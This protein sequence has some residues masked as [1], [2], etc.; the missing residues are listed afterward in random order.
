MPIPGNLTTVTV[1]GAY[2]YT[3]GSPGV[4]TVSFTPTG[5]V[6]LR[7]ATAP[8]TVVAKKVEVTLSGTGTFSIALPATDDTD[9]APTGTTYDVVETVGAVTRTYSISLPMADTTVDIAELAPVAPSGSVS[10]LVLKVNNKLPNS[11][12]EVTLVHTDVGAAGAT[13]T[14]NALAGKAS[15]AHTHTQA[16][17][18]GLVSGLAAKVNKYTPVALTYGATLT[19]DATI[20][21]HYRVTLTGNATLAEPTGG[22]DGQMILLEVKQDGTGG[23]TLTNGADVLLGDDVTSMALSTGAGKT[24]LVLLLNNS[25]AGKWMVIGIIHGYVL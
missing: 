12:G 5:G 19:I 7:D 17:I 4:G 6:W 22:E 8:V 15:T 3:D 21:R 23:R 20:G 1:T 25:G 18:T 14:T 2:V 9:V 24:D 10:Q 13:D 11:A 16:E